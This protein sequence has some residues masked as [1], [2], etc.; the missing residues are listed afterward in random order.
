M[1]I[2]WNQQ[3]SKHP[4]SPAPANTPTPEQKVFPRYHPNDCATAYLDTFKKVC[5]DYQIP[6]TE[7]ARNLRVYA[8][9]LLLNVLA[10]LTGFRSAKFELLEC[11]LPE[12]YV[13]SYCI[14]DPNSS[15]VKG[16]TASL[17]KNCCEATGVSCLFFVEESLWKCFSAGF[18]R[19]IS[20]SGLQSP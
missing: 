15:Q 1:R 9:D 12:E 3:K 14:F 13:Y 16:P 10:E 20:V 5:R 11:A 7:Y 6:V 2:T 19:Q 18:A 4:S 8:Q 17:M